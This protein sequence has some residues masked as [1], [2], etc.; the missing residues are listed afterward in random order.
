MG[1]KTDKYHHGNLKGALLKAGL[2]LVERIG[3]ERFTLREVAR[4][5]GVSHNAPYRHFPSKE[6]LLAALA[7]D[8]LRQLHETLRLAVGHSAQPAARLH[9]AAIAYLRFAVKNPSRFNIMFHSA[10]DRAAYPD[11]VAASAGLLGLL[12]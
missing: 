9:D 11:Y 6:S 12:S 7:A 1:A 5:A 2:K 10:F 3:V 8:S 4:K